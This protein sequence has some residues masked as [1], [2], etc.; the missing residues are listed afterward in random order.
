[1]PTR[2]AVVWLVGAVLALQPLAVLAS[3]LDRFAQ[4]LSTTQSAKGEFEQKVVDQGGRPLSGERS[5]G[6]GSNEICSPDDNGPTC[7]VGAALHSV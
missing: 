2:R 7:A 4:F 6:D 1:M 3:S 5:V